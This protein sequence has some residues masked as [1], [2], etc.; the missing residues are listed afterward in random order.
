MQTPVEC[1]T[2]RTNR[3]T[4]AAGSDFRIKRDPAK[5]AWW[6]AAASTLTLGV[7]TMKLLIVISA[8]IVLPL[9]A[10]AQIKYTSTERELFRIQREWLD[11]YAKRDIRLFARLEAADFVRVDENGNILTR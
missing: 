1:K 8:V 10:M 9:G 11:A 7:F 2:H 3:W 6:R 5:G 4:R